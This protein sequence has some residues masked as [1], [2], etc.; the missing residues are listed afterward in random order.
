MRWTFWSIF[1]GMSLCFANA[2]CPPGWDLINQ[3]CYKFINGHLKFNTAYDMCR[4]FGGKIFEPKYE[5]E[6]ELV[7][8]FYNDQRVWIGITDQ[9]SEGRYL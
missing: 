3:K 9:D 6:E 7:M 8:D 2:V 5:M 1:F 4:T